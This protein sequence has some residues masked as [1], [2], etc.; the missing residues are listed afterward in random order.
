MREV[1]EFERKVAT[2]MAR[3]AIGFNM[4]GE[5]LKAFLTRESFMRTGSIVAAVV[6]KQLVADA[7]Q[8]Y[9]KEEA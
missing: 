8:W 3:T 6:S 7:D 1:T 9:N 2:D 5:E 4:Q